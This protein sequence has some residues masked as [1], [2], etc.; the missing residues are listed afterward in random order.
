MTVVY[1]TNFTH[2]PNAYLTLAVQRAAEA[3]FGAANVV[4]ADNRDL[5]EIAATGEHATLIC[6]DGQRLNRAVIERVRPAFRTMILWLFEDPFMLSYN[7]SNADLFDFVFTNDPDCAGSYGGTGY[8]L[9]LGASHSLQWRPLLNDDN[10]QYDIFFAGTMWPNRVGTVRGLLEHFSDKRFKLVCPT[11]PFLPPLPRD[12]AAR[13][14]Q[15]PVSHESFVEF[16]NAS[17]VTLTMFRDYASHGE[18]SQASAPGPRL[19]EL[20]LAGTAQIVE[21]DSTT[22]I[23]NFDIVDGVSCCKSF[24]ELVTAISSVLKD[25]DLRHARAKEAQCSIMERHLYEH[26]LQQIASITGA[27][28]ERAPKP[29]MPRDLGARR[30]RVLMCSHSTMHEP[31]WGGVEVYQQTLIAALANNAEVFYWLRKHQTCTFMRSTGEVLDQ[32]IVQ[33]IGWLDSLTDAQEEVAFAKVISQYDI[34]LVHFQHLGHH[35]TSL[36]IIA[37]SCGVGTVLSIHDFYIVCSRYNLLDH[38]MN[39]CDIGNRTVT[40]CDIC[41]QVAE[42]VAP[43]GQETRRAFVAEMLRSVDVLLFGTAYSEQLSLRIYPGLHEKR[44][45][46]LGIPTSTSVRA[47]PSRPLRPADARLKVAVIGNFLRQKGADT[48]LRIIETVEPTLFEFHLLGK[49]EA[50]YEDVLNRDKRPNIIYHGRHGI[51]DLDEL[52]N[53]DVAVFLSIWPETFCISLSEAWQR[54]VVPIVT[55]MGA[56]GDRVTHGGNGFVVEAHDAAAVIGYLELLRADPATLAAMRS[57]ITPELWTATEPYAEAILGIYRSVVPRVSLGVTPLGFDV[58]QLHLLPHRRWRDLASPRHILDPSRR[59]D[60]GLDLPHG[61]TSWINVDAQVYIDTV[62]RN[63]IRR[64]EAGLFEASDQVE[65]TGWAYVPDVGISGQVI[66]AL[67]CEAAKPSIFLK[68][69]RRFRADVVSVFPNAPNQAGFSALATLRGKWSDGSYRIAIINTLG[70]R[71]VFTLTDCRI[72]LRDGRVIA[73]SVQKSTPLEAQQSFEQA[74]QRTPNLPKCLPRPFQ[75]AD[76][77]VSITQSLE[78]HLDNVGHDCKAEL[79]AGDIPPSASLYL[80]GWAIQ[81]PAKAEAGDLYVGLVCE[82]DD[83]PVFT[84]AS[85]QMRPDVR[86][87]FGQAPDH[88]GFVVDLAVPRAMMDGICRL[89]LC[90]VVETLAVVRMTWISFTVRSGKFMAVSFNDFDLAAQE[91]LYARIVKRQACPGEYPA[92]EAVTPTDSVVRPA[93]KRRSHSRTRIEAAPLV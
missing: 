16:A 76:F 41:L 86:S 17:R 36:P 19:F 45:E 79:E 57:R 5:I 22:N 93:R 80:R 42:G 15:W 81:K 8:Y 35:V 68:A 56:L 38:S 34:D 72:L 87:A 75:L 10:L 40:A 82:N 37:K 65:V 46:V 64:I 49:A 77:P 51:G 27:S 63:T 11:N 91:T 29:I 39:F 47:A 6:L 92:P 4:V 14:I 84:K 60:I 48:V 90:N 70:H 13:A 62:S 26:R 89:V 53:C 59:S 28:F 12:I 58:G 33:E 67:V 1:N 50:Q 73:A 9:G 30:L 2:N 23:S 24:S 74:T 66:V 25:P 52:D 31:D 71:A 61:I 54:G 3:V 20:G 83:K 85:R 7:Q 21:V 44:R 78:W 18:V 43:G 55:A 32:F 88:C 69:S